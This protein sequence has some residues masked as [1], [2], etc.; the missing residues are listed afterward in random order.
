MGQN[1]GKPKQIATCQF[2]CIFV[3]LVSYNSIAWFYVSNVLLVLSSIS[4]I[5]IDIPARFFLGTVKKKSPTIT[6]TL[7]NHWVGVKGLKIIYIP[8]IP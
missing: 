3:C 1:H 8:S 2:S 4:N 5:P 7:E 6:D